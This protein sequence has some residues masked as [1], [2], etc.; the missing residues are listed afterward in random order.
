MSR[1]PS[2]IEELFAESAYIARQFPVVVV[3]M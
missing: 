3:S 2:L 1:G